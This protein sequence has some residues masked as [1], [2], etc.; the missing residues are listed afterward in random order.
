MV[1]SAGFEPAKFL[2]QSQVT[3]PF[4][5]QES[6]AESDVHDTYGLHHVSLSGRTQRLAGSLSIWLS[7]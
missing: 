5:L 3:F 1:L 2:G 7:S 4:C 6:M